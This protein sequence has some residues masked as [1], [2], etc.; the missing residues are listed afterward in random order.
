MLRRPDHLE[1]SA[2]RLHLAHR[3]PHGVATAGRQLF[4][5]PGCPRVTMVRSSRRCVKGEIPCVIGAWVAGVPDYSP[6]AVART[7]DHLLLASAGTRAR[8]R[9]PER[10]GARLL[11]RRWDGRVK[12]ATV[13]S[14]R[15]PRRR[16]TR[17]GSL[18]SS[19]GRPAR[20]GGQRHAR[21]GICPAEDDRHWCTT[22]APHRAGAINGGMLTREGP[23]TSPVVTVEVDDIDKALETIAAQGGSTVRGRNPSQTWGSRPTSPTPKATSWACGRTP[24]D[25]A[26]EPRI[27]AATAG[28]GHG[29]SHV[30]GRLIAPRSLQPSRVRC[31]GRQGGRGVRVGSIQGGGWKRGWP[32]GP[33]S[34]SQPWWWMRR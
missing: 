7:S 32:S 15:D 8:S 31:G 29:V 20:L 10:R 3:H 6:S 14:A 28:A 5:G 25:V 18:R 30:H 13:V 9:C 27:A 16:T 19:T 1:V 4:V 11:R 2:G 33:R 34:T 26:I 21:H 17:P 23:F 24:A 12:A 22:G